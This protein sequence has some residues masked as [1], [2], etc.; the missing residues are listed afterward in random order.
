LFIQ[1]N[2]RGN[3]SG[4][5]DPRAFLSGQ[6]A[7]HVVGKPTGGAREKKKEGPEHTFR[8]VDTDEWKLI[9]VT[10]PPKKVMAAGEL[11]QISDL[12]PYARKAFGYTKALNQIQSIVFPVAFKQS[13][14]MIIAAPTGA[15]KTNVALL[16]ILR[17]LSQHLD[18]ASEGPWDLSQKRFQ[19]VYIAPLKALAAE[20][21]AKF[22]T[23]LGYLGL[24]V[25]ELTG[26][27]SI[28]KGEIGETHVI[29]ATPEKWDVVTRKTDG[30][31][32]AVN[33]LIIDEIH[34]LNDGRGLVLECLVARAIT[35]G[36]KNQKPI[37]IVGLSATLPNYQ[38][39]AAFIGADEK[40]TFYFDGS[41][42]PTP[43]KCSFYGVRE[44]SNA[45]RAN[46]VMNTIIYDQLK[47]II[48]L[49]KQA[50]I[51]AH[52]RAETYTT[53]LEIIEMLKEQSKDEHLY[54]CED[55]WKS[56]AEVSRSGN[57][58]IKDL[59]PHGFGLHHAG[60]LRKDRTLVEK[61][62]SEGHIKVL[63]STATLAWGVNLPAYAVI[64]KGTKV[65]DSNAGGY[66]D[67]GVFD[68]QQIFGRAGRPQFDVEGEGIILTQFK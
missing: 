41:Y 23:A 38:D 30:M 36:L 5:L 29:V 57:Q 52:K 25:R 40:G 19:V 4:K 18:P 2:K 54:D 16:T 62:F 42:R 51:F 9:E 3:R 48:T 31:M 26:D 43:L 56:K 13:R 68:V 27:M 55:S 8:E 46:N 6:V 37:R 7:Q 22:T 15:G 44:L 59:F 17:E 32:D 20:I 64:I 47:R 33:C 28:S 24:K 21:V 12:P 35:T 10:P 11:V 60:M 58:Q 66:K 14:S 53:A 67:V 1:E 65:Y 39:V 63:C 49:G 50:I 61:M 45:K 34:L